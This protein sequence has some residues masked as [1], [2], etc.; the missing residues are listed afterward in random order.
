MGSKIPDG[1]AGMVDYRY[2]ILACLEKIILNVK[3]ELL[4]FAKPEDD[5]ER[6]IRVP[7]PIYRFT[8]Y[9]FFNIS[10]DRKKLET[11]FFNK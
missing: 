5:L 11:V 7:G 3:Y 10:P 4:Q 9:N 2:R 8:I 6:I 1:C